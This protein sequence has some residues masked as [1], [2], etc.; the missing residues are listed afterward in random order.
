VV[1]GRYRFSTR[2]PKRI[3]YGKRWGSYS[4]DL[5]MPSGEDGDFREAYRLLLGYLEDMWLDAR[6][7]INEFLID[8]FI[9]VYGDDE[10]HSFLA[11]L[12]GMPI[13]K[14]EIDAIRIPPQ[15]SSWFGAQPLVA[16]GWMSFGYQDPEPFN[17]FAGSYQLLAN[18]SPPFLGSLEYINHEHSVFFPKSPR[19]SGVWVKPAWG[20]QLAVRVF[21]RSV[22]NVLEMDCPQQKE[23]NF[24]I[25]DSHPDDWEWHIKQPAQLQPISFGP[26]PIFRMIAEGDAQLQLP[27]WATIY[28]LGQNFNI[29]P[30]AEQ[31]NIAWGNTDHPLT[32]MTVAPDNT[33]VISYTLPPLMPT[34]PSNP[35]QGTRSGGLPL[36]P[37]PDHDLGG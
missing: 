1:Y 21:C 5:W 9:V 25:C 28:E 26:P 15:S 10:W 11:E 33:H 3:T 2:E 27:L 4:Q 36:F 17:S 29:S 37:L 7:G 19:L 35:F 23:P 13:T 20:F 24:P 14:V 22:K 8:E 18:N 32:G 16:A 30:S 12:D 6:N 34:A 31:P